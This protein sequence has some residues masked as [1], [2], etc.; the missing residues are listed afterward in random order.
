MR[1]GKHKIMI[2]GNG[3]VRIGIRGDEM[4]RRTGRSI[5][6]ALIFFA[7]FA[8]ALFG[9]DFTLSKNDVTILSFAAF[10]PWFVAGELN[11]WIP[12]FDLPWE[13]VYGIM[14]L[15]SLG[16]IFNGQWVE[17]LILGGI[18]S[19]AVAGA[20]FT[21][22]CFPLSSFTGMTA[23]H[24]SFYSQYELYKNSRMMADPASYLHRMQ[25]VDMGQAALA[26]FRFDYLAD[27]FVSLFLLGEIV[28]A[29]AV[30]H[31]TNGPFTPPTDPFIW[32]GNTYP[33]AGG[34]ALYMGEL[35]YRSYW[36][37]LGEEAQFRGFLLPE[38]TEAMGPLLAC[39]VNGL[40]FTLV[41][42]NKSMDFGLFALN[43]LYSFIPTG[44]YLSY[45][46]YRD[47]FD[48]RKAAF[49]HFW[50]DFALGMI[51]LFYGDQVQSAAV[52]YTLP[53]FCVSF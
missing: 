52:A 19:A 6:I 27:P 13:A 41:H 49:A 50:Y 31:F 34:T 47:D 9:Q 22:A 38:M 28:G 48:F 10:T 37:A 39:I 45:L 2:G 43:A 18:D 1:A 15:N 5:A 25:P 8:P 23:S 42:Y 32:H 53:L 16:F 46:S 51:Y 12:G 4:R 36:A 14:P 3:T 11:R 21:R 44:I 7:F 26:P 17:G 33:L 40:Y 29:W 30:N 24:L 35:T 20:Y